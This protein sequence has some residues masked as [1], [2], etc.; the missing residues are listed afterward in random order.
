[1][2]I[3]T[4]PWFSIKIDGNQPMDSNTSLWV[5]LF[6]IVDPMVGCWQGK[7]SGDERV[8]YKMYAYWV[9]RTATLVLVVL[10]NFL[11]WPCDLKRPRLIQEFSIQTIKMKTTNNGGYT[12]IDGTL[13][14]RFNFVQ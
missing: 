10:D 12:S 2:A 8:E 14:S 9:T 11:I 4:T 5:E 6:V 1:M 7:K 3:V 13:L